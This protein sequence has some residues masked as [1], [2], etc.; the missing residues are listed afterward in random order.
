MGFIRSSTASMTVV[1]QSIR[2]ND[3]PY[4]RACGSLQ[5]TG[6]PPASFAGAFG[7]EPSCI[8]IS[9][10]TAET[11][12]GTIRVSDQQASHSPRMFAALTIGHHF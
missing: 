8:G 9:R 11:R 5:R 1:R 2:P 7:R 12:N 10:R 4:L 3:W 6:T